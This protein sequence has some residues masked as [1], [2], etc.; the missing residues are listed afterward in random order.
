MTID[1]IGSVYPSESGIIAA[2]WGEKEEGQLDE[3]AEC[4]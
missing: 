1:F 3:K 4:L 2:F